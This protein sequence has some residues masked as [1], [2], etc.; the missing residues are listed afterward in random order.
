MSGI[1]ACLESYFPK[2]LTI[3]PS[4]LETQLGDITTDRFFDLFIQRTFWTS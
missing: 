2:I 1:F 4:F 3:L